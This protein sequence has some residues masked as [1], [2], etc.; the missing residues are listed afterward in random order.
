MQFTSI[1]YWHGLRRLGLLGLVLLTGCND[2]PAQTPDASAGDSPTATEATRPADAPD[3]RQPLFEGLGNPH[4]AITTNSPTA[5]RYFDQGLAL[6]YAFNHAAAD[7]AFT[8]ATLHDPDCG[9]CYWGSALVLGPNVNAAMDP[10]NA[11]RAHALATRAHELTAAASPKE[12]A[13]T[14]AL[15]ERYR[16]EAPDDRTPLDTAYADAMRRVAAQYADDPNV[17]ALTAEALMD[18]HPWDFWL[19]DGEER[20]WTAEIVATIEQALAI[21]PD[22]VGAIHLYIHAVEQSRE[23]ARAEPYADRLADLAPSAGHLVHM[24]AHIYIRIGRY[25]DATLNNMKAADAD[26]AFVQ[27]CRSNSPIYLAGY[28]PHNWHFGWVTAAIE[29]WSEQA[30]VMARGTASL[31]SPELLRAPDMAV[32]QHFLVQPLFAQVRFGA[33]D[34][35]LAAPEP[36]ADLLYARGVWHYA[37]GRAFAGQGDIARARTEADALAALRAHPD[38]GTLAFFGRDGG[39]PL[40]AIAA[41]MLDGEIALAAGDHAGA[42]DKLSAAVRAEDALN[43][44]EPP[45]WFYPARHSLGHAQL[46]AGQHVAAESTYRAD[47]DIMPENGWALI[48]LEQALR[49]QGRD[50]EAEDVRKRF[51][52]AWRHADIT[53]TSSRI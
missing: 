6:A 18:L 17:L 5:Q 4:I 43:Y 38:I 23:A 51:E 39:V 42:V 27:A 14:A 31:L 52:T 33:W 10:A 32:A 1:Q 47:L 49:A 22:H 48:G 28:M 13:L 25:H 16:S 40:L 50:S 37:R 24:P 20:P 12:R 8:E 9:M 29:G 11:A 44:T 53:I 35:I 21:D 46:A 3:A 7:L 41:Q 30:M 26:T 45:D 15:V 36:D 19:A 34:D 2:K